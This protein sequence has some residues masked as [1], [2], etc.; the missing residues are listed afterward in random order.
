TVDIEYSY[1]DE[2]CEYVCMRVSTSMINDI[3]VQLMK[4]TT[5]IGATITTIQQ[6]AVANSINIINYNINNNNK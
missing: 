1:T 3:N 5:D 2:E 6:L 4:E